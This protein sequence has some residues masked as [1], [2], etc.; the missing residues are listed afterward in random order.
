MHNL[1]LSQ[2]CWWRIKVWGMTSCRF[3]IRYRRLGEHTTSILGVEE[4]KL[5]EGNSC[6]MYG[7]SELYDGRIKPTCSCWDYPDDGAGKLI[8]TTS[9]LITNRHGIICQN[10]WNGWFYTIIVGN[11]SNVWLHNL[12]M[13]SGVRILP[14]T[15]VQ[16]WLSATDVTPI[17][18]YG[19]S[20]WSSPPCGRNVCINNTENWI[21][22]SSNSSV[23]SSILCLFS[24]RYNPLW[25]YFHSPVAGFSLLIFEVSWS[26]TT[27]R[28]SR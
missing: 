15:Q 2:R 21:T 26:H 22:R 27:T 19:V 24:W 12:T 11:D 1:T 17:P 5:H 16:R 18:D 10:S 6:I 20:Q 13:R 9:K 4:R 8:Q 28:H 23:L 25:L 3:E 7:K 14:I